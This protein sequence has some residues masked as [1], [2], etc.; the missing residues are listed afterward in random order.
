MRRVVLSLSFGG[1]VI[2]VRAHYPCDED[3]Y[4]S[5]VV[6]GFKNKPQAEEYQKSVQAVLD[7]GRAGAPAKPSTIRMRL[8]KLENKRKGV[9]CSELFF[10][11]EALRLRK[12]LLRASRDAREVQA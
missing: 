3:Q 4:A 7:S 8:A 10:M 9:P 11:R 12:V 6:A 1:G 5:A 2:R